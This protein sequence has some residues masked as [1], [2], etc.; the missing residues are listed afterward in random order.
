M[1]ADEKAEVEAEADALLD[2]ILAMLNRSHLNEPQLEI[3]CH[4]R[5][6]I[7][8]LCSVLGSM[9][10]K[11]CRQLAREHIEDLLPEALDNVMKLPA[12]KGHAH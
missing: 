8:A 1:T 12:S 11:G 10:C 6:L 7:A 3:N 4:I 2:N 9:T 5:A